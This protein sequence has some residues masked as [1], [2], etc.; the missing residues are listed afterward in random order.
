MA[1]IQL[2]HVSL[3]FHVRHQKRVPLKDYLL[4]RMFLSSAPALDVPAL[5]DLTF[6]VNEGDRLAIVGHNGAGKSTLLKL[7]AGV[8][9]PTS[10][11]RIV[12]GQISSM[13]DLMLGFEPE[14]TGWENIAYR[15][16]LQGETPRSIRAKMNSI[17][18]FSELGEFLNTPVRYY[19]SGMTVRLAFAIATAV[20]PEILL[21]DEVLSVGDM[22]FQTKARQ[23]M[24]EMIHRA[25]LIVM[26]GHDLGALRIFCSRALWMDHGQMRMLG[27][28]DEVI[29]AYTERMCSNQPVPPGSTLHAETATTAGTAASS[30]S[31]SPSGI[32]SGT[33]LTAP[34]SHSPP[35]QPAIA[36]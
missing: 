22:A 23:R 16:Y 15:G 9:P 14:A 20:D 27:T 18:E 30:G 29:D 7:L 36:A 33:G 10:G 21:I 2:D 19:S 26:V 31:L 34:A 8:Y 17:A 11:K 3:T 4:K 6:N 28:P 35:D 12:E 5:C 32:A 1:R 24:K 25:R 13:F